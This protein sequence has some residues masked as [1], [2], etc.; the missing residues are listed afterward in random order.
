[1]KYI[2]LLTMMILSLT[3]FRLARRQKEWFQP[4]FIFSV[5]ILL[6]VWVNLL[7]YDKRFEIKS[8]TYTLYLAS[9][10]T[11]VCGLQLGTFSNITI[12]FNK[13]GKADDFI[14]KIL[15]WFAVFSSFFAIKQ[16]ISGVSYGI[17]GNNLIDNVRF[18]SQYVDNGNF[19]SE[20]GIVA[21]DVLMVYLMYRYY[22]EGDSSRHVRN[23]II[24]AVA[25][26]I[27]FVATV[28]NRTNILYLAIIF[29]FFFLKKKNDFSKERKI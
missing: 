13:R 11:F 9:V 24:F 25:L 28:F 14:Y 3:G 5:P 19:F 20:Y 10:L 16:I 7:M 15:W 23:S 1:M 21:C 6:S 18:Y 27:L 22:I 4:L 17:Y 26:Y 8:I 2:L 12:R 29:S